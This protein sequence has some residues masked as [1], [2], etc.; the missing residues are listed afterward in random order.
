M[1]THRA[2][3]VGERACV[4]QAL[5]VHAQVLSEEIICRQL[6]GFLWRDEGQVHRRSWVE[7]NQR[8]RKHTFL[9]TVPRHSVH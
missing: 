3:R 6:D 9:T 5:P 1:G 8:N 2:N 4:F 7:D